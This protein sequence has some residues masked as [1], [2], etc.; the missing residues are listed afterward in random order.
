MIAV[1][2]ILAVLILIACLP[3][4]IWLGFDGEGA[5][6]KVCIGFLRI[7]VYP[8][9]DKP[10]TEVQKPAAASFEKKKEEPRGGSV[11]DFFPLLSDVLKFL[12]DF[13]RKLWVKELKLHIV[14]GG[15]DPCDL[16]VNY[17]RAWAG[18]GNLLPL[19]ERVLHIRK[20]DLQVSCDFTAEATLITGRLYITISLGRLLWISLR[21][22]IPGIKKFLQILNK[23]KGGVV[24][25]E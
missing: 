25:N 13:R 14:L 8:F 20:R 3:L 11:T 6:V 1:L 18:I 16:A 17:G 7:G 12:D 22:G 23:R 21:R 19:L 4:G 10:K 2:I 24:T 9:K 15:G 5:K